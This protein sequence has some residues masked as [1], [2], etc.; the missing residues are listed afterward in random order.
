LEAGLKL[1]TQVAQSLK[2]R[3]AAEP[4]A[5]AV[6][7]AWDGSEQKARAR[8]EGADLAEIA[9]FDALAEEWWNPDGAFKNG[10]CV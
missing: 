8:G 7:H 10:P 4:A 2:C 6:T 9:R 5:E 1:T 3:G